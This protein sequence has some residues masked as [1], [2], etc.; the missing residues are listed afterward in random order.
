MPRAAVP[1]V[2]EAVGSA[3]VITAPFGTWFEPIM[4]I[5]RVATVPSD[6]P[7]VGACV[8]VIVVVV[9]LS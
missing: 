4:I 8:V 5:G 1:C 7:T 2:T 6:R 3:E 9:I